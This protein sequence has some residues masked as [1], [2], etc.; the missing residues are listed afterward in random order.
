M[1]LTLP[2]RPSDEALQLYQQLSA[3]GVASSGAVAASEGRLHSA[4]SLQLPAD[5]SSIR[6]LSTAQQLMA[7]TARQTTSFIVLAPG[8]Y[9]LPGP[10]DGAP[11]S[12]GCTILGLGRVILT[13]SVSHAAWVRQGRLTLV[14]VQLVGSCSGAAVC[15]SPQPS[16]GFGLMGLLRGSGAG[17][18]TA[19]CT[20]ID[21]GVESY[22]EVGLLVCGEGAE[23]VLHGCS[24]RR[25]KLQA[26][27]VR[28][29]GSLCASHTVIEHCMQGISAY[30]GAKRVELY[31]C[32]IQNTNRE[33]VLAAGSFE[34]AATAA[35]G[36]VRDPRVS[37]HSSQSAKSAS[38][39]A[40]A[41]GK[42]K[43]Q[44]LALVMQDCSLKGCGNFGVSIDSGAA[45]K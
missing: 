41:W 24:F 26:V 7:A 34:N 45:G 37:A 43:G 38:E 39:A 19:H 31:S 4:G 27:E 12:S 32:S 23:A 28:Q 10:L 21:C 33:G 13:C 3:A 36:E 16:R 20:M 1:A 6:Y 14:N 17:A 44:Q 25:C 29:G 2:D 42:Q 18:G 9:N 22:P 40:D 11:S 35:Q 15:A 30:G 8:T 5:H